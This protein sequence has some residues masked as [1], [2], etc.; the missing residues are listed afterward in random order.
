MVNEAT[1]HPVASRHPSFPKEG[2]LYII[3]LGKVSSFWKEEYPNVSE[4]R[5]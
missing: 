4:G 5:W 2:I 1:Y 3:A